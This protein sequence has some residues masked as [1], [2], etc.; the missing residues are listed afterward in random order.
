MSLDPGVADGADGVDQVHGALAVDEQVCTTG[1]PWRTAAGGAEAELRLSSHTCLLVLGCGAP[2]QGGNT[3][4]G[5]RRRAPSLP[6]RAA[7]GD[8]TPVGPRPT[9]LRH[10]VGEA[11]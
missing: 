4:T 7:S 10:R 5:R 3:K 11:S 8:P 2:R 9:R 6:S 1:L